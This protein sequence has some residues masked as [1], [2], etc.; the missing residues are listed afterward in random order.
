MVPDATH[1]SF[2]MPS[3]IWERVIRVAD[4]IEAI[5]SCAISVPFPG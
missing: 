1:L 2:N 3:N 4:P 5:T